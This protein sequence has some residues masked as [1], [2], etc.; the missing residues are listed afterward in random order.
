[1]LSKKLKE[2]VAEADTNAENAL[3]CLLRA[4]KLLKLSVTCHAHYTASSQQY[5]EFTFQLMHSL[6]SLMHHGLDAI[7]GM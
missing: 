4:V 7:P 2:A 3:S 6:N 1:M 5:K